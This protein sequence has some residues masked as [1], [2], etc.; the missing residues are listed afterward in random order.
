MSLN[1]SESLINKVLVVAVEHDETRIWL[2]NSEAE[3]PVVVITRPPKSTVH[4]RGSQERH[5]HKNEIGMPKYFKEI[6]E[7]MALGSESILIGH[8]NGNANTAQKLMNYLE[9]HNHPSVQK[10]AAIEKRDLSAMSNR[11]LL[12]EARSM[13][14]QR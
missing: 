2:M 9:L 10:V 12:A 14:N 13:W 11:Q 1:I 3:V 7:I 6:S 5:M 4:V 8:G